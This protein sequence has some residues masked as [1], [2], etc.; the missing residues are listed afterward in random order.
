MRERNAYLGGSSAIVAAAPPSCKQSPAKLSPAAPSLSP[1]LLL[2]LL[3]RLPPPLDPSR[4]N[5]ACA[6]SV[7]TVAEAAAASSPTPLSNDS[8]PST[9]MVGAKGAFG[10]GGKGGKVES[11]K[12]LVARS[13]P[14]KCSPGTRLGS[15]ATM[16]PA[17]VARR[18]T[19]RE[20]RPPHRGPPCSARAPP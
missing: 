10:S 17:W 14:G 19:T 9:S 5:I 12:R 8:E 1:L 13:K 15:V 4:A 20:T 6:S 7:G 18:R 3:L 2:L 16:V 11:R